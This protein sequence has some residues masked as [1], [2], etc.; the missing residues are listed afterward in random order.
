MADQPEAPMAP[1]GYITLFQQEQMA[2]RTIED[3]IQSMLDG[4]IGTGR[5]IVRVRT[6][7]NPDGTLQ[8]QHVALSVDKTKSVQDVTTREYIEEERTAEEIDQ[9]AKLAMLAAGLDKERGR[10]AVYPIHFDK[11]QEIAARKEAE[12]Q[13]RVRF[14]TRG[15]LLVLIAAAFFLLRW[16]I[17]RKPASDLAAFFAQPE[18]KAA[19]M[20]AA[21]LFFCAGALGYW[22]YIMN[23]NGLVIVPGIF[24]LLVGL[25]RGWSMLKAEPAKI[26]ATKKTP[27]KTS[28]RKKPPA[29]PS[30]PETPPV[31]PDPAP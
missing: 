14:W 16:R 20:V 13:G 8:R 4:L 29:T 15:P 28:A 22:G 9:L 30:T 12:Q 1:T 27:A 31:D 19:F 25:Y 11:T 17:R 18:N 10:I 2:A 21:G 23:W 6:L 24:L 26:S 3:Q 7:L 5:S